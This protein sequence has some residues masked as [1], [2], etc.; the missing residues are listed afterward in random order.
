MKAPPPSAAA[1]AR[2]LKR[3]RQARARFTVQAIYD[4]FV[5][6][7]QRDGWDRLTTRNV[8]LET[9]IAVGTLYDYFPNKTALLSGYVRHCLEALL[10][11]IEREAVQPA[12]L[13]W[14]ERIHHL[15]RLVCGVD[16][17]E[18]PTFHPDMLAL[19]GAMAE[20]HHHRRAH[21]E[22]AA[23]WGRVLDACTDLPHPL[24]PGLA[25]ALHLSAWG[26][27]RYVLLLQLDTAAMRQWA[28]GVEQLCYAAI[29]Q[30]PR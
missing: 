1:A 3:P 24:A 9:G 23:A 6:I 28:D 17:P 25:Q 12:G 2:P 10:A 5:R 30:A 27:R 21:E 22:L 29:R 15:V 14:E 20:P 19:E 11:A 4:A 8:A 18:L 13:P 16:A 7:W 26:G